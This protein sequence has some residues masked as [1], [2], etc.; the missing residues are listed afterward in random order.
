MKGKAHQQ[1]WNSEQDI[2]ITREEMTG[3]YF[4]GRFQKTSQITTGIPKKHPH[5]LGPTQDNHPLSPK[6]TR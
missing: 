4:T 1:L 3:K 6:A 5:C 2:Q